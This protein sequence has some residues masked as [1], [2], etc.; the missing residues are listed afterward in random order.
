MI[1]PTVVVMIVAGFHVPGILLVDVT[2]RA[3][4]AV[5]WVKGPICVNVGV[6][7]LVTTTFIVV[8]DA[9]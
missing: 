1:V 4:A 7:G 2:G 6:T 3:G 5:F 8:V 9:P